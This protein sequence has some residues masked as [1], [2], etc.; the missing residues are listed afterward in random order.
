MT[1]RTG[2]YIAGAVK[3]WALT[4]CRKG[5]V[6]TA[7]FDDPSLTTRLWP[8]PQPVRIVVDTELR[9]PQG[10]QLF[11][12]SVSTLVFN[13]H[14]HTV[15]DQVPKGVGYYQ[16]TPDVSLVQQ[17]LHGLYQLKVQSLLVEG[18]AQLL[19]S[20]ID[21]RSWDEARIITNEA[22]TLGPGLPAPRLGGAV[23]MKTEQ[24]KGDVIGYWRPQAKQNHESL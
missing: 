8:G 4:G 13:Y 21:E 14:R 22:L 18:G 23:L 7:L 20:F 19:Q 3:R 5:A 24:L 6:N 10:L 17:L 9:L 15:G 2:W 11:D 1:G 12:G 16:V